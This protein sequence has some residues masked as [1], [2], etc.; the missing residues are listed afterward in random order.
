MKTKN[1]KQI[2][3]FAQRKR[4]KKT[5][6][7]KAKALIGKE[8][9]SREVGRTF[10]KVSITVDILTR[11]FITAPCIDQLVYLPG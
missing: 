6:L 11:D 5:A 2:V 8:R 4:R 9:L 10:I 3:F 7:S 1:M